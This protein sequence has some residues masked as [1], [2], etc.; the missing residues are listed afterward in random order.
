MTQSILGCAVAIISMT[1]LV[2]LPARAQD[3][4]FEQKLSDIKAAM[5]A[6]QQMLGQ[7]IWQE[8]ETISVKGNVKDT[9]IYQVRLG[10]DGKQQKTEISDE[11]AQSGGHEGRLK[12]HIIEEK[13]EEFKEYGQSIG[14][15]AKQ[16]TQSDPGRLEQARAQ[17][18]ISLRP[19]GAD[20]TISLV[21]QNYVKQGDS[22]T[23]TV[24][25]QTHGPLSATISSYLNDPSDAVQIT[26]QFSRLPDG[27]NHVSSVE[28]NGVSKHLTVAEQNSNYQHL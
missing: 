19:E 3:P 18:N 2:V 21:I 26:A 16:Y 9:R 24:D 7:Y 17:G 25:K 5:A 20:G 22:L 28:I 14:A 1:P 13:Q 4:Q 11:K 15:L 23:L 6:N 27:T 10:P 12:K 8:Q